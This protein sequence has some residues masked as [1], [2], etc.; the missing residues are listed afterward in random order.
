VSQALKIGL[1]LPL[2]GGDAASFGRQAEAGLRLFAAD[3]NSA[4]GIRIDYARR[5]VTIR[6][7]DDRGDPARCADIYRSLCF[8]DR[9]DLLF[10]PC[11]GPML[12][13]AVP[14]AEEARM[15]LVNHGGVADDLHGVCRML[16]STAAPAV[17]YLSGVA[18][19]LASLKMFRKRL[20]IVSAPTRFARAVADGLEKAAGER[21]ARW[22]GVRLRLKYRGLI[23]PENPPHEL[24]RALRRNRVN[25]FVSAGSLRQDIAAVR[26]AIQSQLY[27]P[28]IACVAAGLNQFGREMGVDAEGIVGASQWE[29]DL[30]LR[31]A[32]GPGPAEFA[33]R[34]RLYEPGVSCDYPAARAYGAG[35][36]AAAAIEAAGVLDQSRLRAAF[37]NL[38]TT[39]T[40]GDFAVDPAGRQTAHKMLLVQ[41]HQGRKVVIDP[42]PPEQ[43]GGVEFRSGLRLMLEALHI[44]NPGRASR[45]RGLRGND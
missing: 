43:Q 41:W 13:A 1:S 9:V 32:L 39:T 7:E 27:I 30:A 20:A 11:F 18:R 37:A 19:L 34:M 15:V 17:L 44:S 29:E 23:D 3:I 2:S 14:I 22:H 40:F 21:A 8:N 38:R 45:D 16:V 28:V 25:A 6:C 5:E 4:G 35:L 31:P 36:A 10:G 12:R 24:M 42:A 33:R 26:F